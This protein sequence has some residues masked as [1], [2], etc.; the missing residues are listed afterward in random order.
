MLSMGGYTDV[1]FLAGPRR[2]V[3]MEGNEANLG[4]GLP[5]PQEVS[6]TSSRSFDNNLALL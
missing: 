2:T 1:T 4:C 5:R 3:G 6:T